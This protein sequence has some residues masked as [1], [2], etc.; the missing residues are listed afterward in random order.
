MRAAADALQSAIDD[1]F[2]ERLANTPK[3]QR[4]TA[5]A[6]LE[7]ARLERTQQGLRLLADHIEAGTVPEPLRGV[8]TKAAVYELARSHIDRS[9]CGYYDAG[10][11]TNT[12]ALD[13]PAARTLWAMLTGPSEADR[14]AA[15]L[16]EQL[17]KLQF[18]NIPDYF[19]TPLPV[20]LDMVR[21]A[22]LPSDGG[23]TLQLGGAPRP[24]S[25]DV[26]EPSAGS[27]AILDALRNHW[28]TGGA[29]LRLTAYERHSTL[30]QILAAK[31]Y[32]LAGS[33]FMAAPAAPQFDRIIMNPP[34]SGGAD[35]KH[36]RHAAA[37]LRPGGLLVAICANGPRQIE[38]LQPLCDH[39]EALPAG[40]FKAAGTSVNT[41]LIVIRA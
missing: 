33:D 41:A 23:N 10:L 5:E 40:S 31:G 1:K 3:R 20:I 12:P 22:E 26:L 9:R 19:P 2:G 18:A 34:F 8:T 6:R 16:R 39:W 13:T 21:L 17:E 7:G 36:I 14:K 32:E 35:I 4:Q 38:H 30:R 27:G 37:M 29:K 25:C 28:G 11:D 24:D 15:D